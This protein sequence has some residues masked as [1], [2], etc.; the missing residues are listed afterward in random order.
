MVFYSMIVNL[1]HKI[2]LFVPLPVVVAL[3]LSS[4]CDV[5]EYGYILE[6]NSCVLMTLSDQ[7]LS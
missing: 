2:L 7:T 6:Y 4:Q 3:N 5:I 1:M